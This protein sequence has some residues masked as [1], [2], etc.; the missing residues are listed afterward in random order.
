MARFPLVGVGLLYQKGYLQQSLNPGRLAA[1]TQS[2]QRFLHA[3]GAA[4]P[5]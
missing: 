3:P 5:G 1:G 2:G 4:G